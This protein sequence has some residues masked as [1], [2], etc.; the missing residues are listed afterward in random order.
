MSIQLVG[1]GILIPSGQP[2][3]SEGD[4]A[5]GCVVTVSDELVRG[6]GA[7]QNQWIVTLDA[8][9]GDGYGTVGRVI[10]TRPKDNAEPFSRCVAVANMPGA[11]GWRVSFRGD[12]DQRAWVQLSGGCAAGAGVPGAY[13]PRPRPRL[14]SIGAAPVLLAGFDVVAFSIRVSD[15]SPLATPIPAG[16][17]WVQ[18]F[19]TRTVAV[20]GSPVIEV[21]IASGGIQQLH[22]DT[23]P[24]VGDAA[25]SEGLVW[26]LSSTPT[27]LTPMAGGQ[28]VNV[29]V[30]IA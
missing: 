11:R 3:V 9:L 21:P 13:S 25:F 28:A 12:K 30:A 20:L 2:I 8:L 22:F 4:D 7:K 24:D 6:A 14:R 16:G 19:N 26:A 29:T 23:Y 17:A 5:S 27:V 10:T 18:F 15:A 1:Q